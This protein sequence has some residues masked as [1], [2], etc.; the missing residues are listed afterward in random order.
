M[1]ELVRVGYSDCPQGKVAIK[2]DAG[3]SNDY[4]LRMHPSD[5]DWRTRLGSALV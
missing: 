4:V 2:R 3:V 1:Y 5:E